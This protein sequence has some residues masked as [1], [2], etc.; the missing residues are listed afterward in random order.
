[1]FTA[2][3]FLKPHLTLTFALFALMSPSSAGR[4][5][6]SRLEPPTATTLDT[7]SGV[8][9]TAAPAGA[10][11][12]A[13]AAAPTAPVETPA[14][15]APAAP[16]TAPFAEGEAAAAA[17]AGIVA[18]VACGPTL[19]PAGEACSSSS[20]CCSSGGCCWSF[21]ADSIVVD[22]GSANADVDPDD[23]AG[24]G[25][26]ATPVTDARVLR[27]IIFLRLLL[28]LLLLLLPPPSPKPPS[29][30]ATTNPNPSPALVELAPP[31]PP[32]FLPAAGLRSAARPVA[33]SLPPPRQNAT[34]GKGTPGGPAEE[35]IEGGLPQARAMSPMASR[36][37]PTRTPSLAAAAP[38]PLL[39]AHDAVGSGRDSPACR[40]RRSCCHC[41]SGVRQRRARAEAGLFVEG[42]CCIAVTVK[43]AAQA[44]VV[45]LVGSSRRRFGV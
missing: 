29:A 18:P 17:A 21:G 4:M 45:H 19:I 16:L 11:A 7:P 42:G 44:S 28:L 22:A 12:A 27:R 23:E 36:P 20:C 40:W 30:G 26:G 32:L 8:R 6:P 13:A 25:R 1:M 35:G 10:A 41:C 31:P 15:A 39:L 2:P 3:Q 24:G 34:D 43:G 5:T 33:V 14:A 9:G 38:P 37:S